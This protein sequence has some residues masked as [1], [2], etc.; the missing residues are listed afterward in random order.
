MC[1]GNYIPQQRTPFTKGK[2]RC[3]EPMETIWLKPGLT[4][5]RI[6]I[7]CKDLIPDTCTDKLKN[8]PVI[9]IL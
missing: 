2:S 6:L 8:A 7:T 9:L 4:R 5:Y 3:Y 1:L